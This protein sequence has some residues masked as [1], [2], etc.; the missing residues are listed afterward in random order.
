MFGQ[1]VCC[2]LA[3]M[4]HLLWRLLERIWPAEDIELAPEF[5][6]ARLASGFEG[7]PW[8]PSK[9]NPNSRDPIFTLFLSC[10]VCA[11]HSP[12]ASYRCSGKAPGCGLCTWLRQAGAPTVFVEGGVECVGASLWRRLTPLE[13]GL[14]LSAH[15][16]TEHSSDKG[17][18]KRTRF[19]RAY[20]DIFLV[21]SSGSK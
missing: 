13:F 4:L 14:S 2:F 12:W 3:A 9:V 6:S 10:G 11:V 7:N 20:S 18:L 16:R 8:A 17:R 19:L 21:V 5:P 15:A 1:A